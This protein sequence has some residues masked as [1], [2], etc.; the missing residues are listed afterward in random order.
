MA[1]TT[2]YLK[3]PYTGYVED[4]RRWNYVDDAA[5]GG[6]LDPDKI[7][8]YLRR[9]RTGGETAKDYQE[10]IDGAEADLLYPKTLG[11]PGGMMAAIEA[12]A[13][14][15]W[16]R[17]N[18]TLGLGQPDEPDLVAGGQ[19]SIA[20]RLTR[21]YDGENTPLRLFWR[22]VPSRMLRREQQFFVVEGQSITRT[23]DEEGN[24][25]NE[26]LT[27]SSCVKAVK[28][29]RV[30]GRRYEGGRLVEAIITGKRE[31][32]AMLEDE[33]QT[34]TTYTHYTL[35]GWTRNILVKGEGSGGE[36]ARVIDS[37][38]Y[39]YYESAEDKRN[40]VRDQPH[41][42]RLPIV[43]TNLSLDG[44]LGYLLAVNAIGIWNM[45]SRRDG[46]INKGN[47]ATR[48]DE[49]PDDEA[50]GPRPSNTS[51]DAH[52]EAAREGY[53]TMQAQPG[54]KVYD[55]APPMAPAQEARATIAEKRAQFKEDA[56]QGFVDA[57]SQ[58][59]ATKIR[60]DARMGIEVLASSLS[61]TVDGAENECMLLIEQ[62]EFPDSPDQWHQFNVERSEAFAPAEPMAVFQEEKE[63]I[64]GSQ[65]TVP[66]TPLQ[67]A[68]W[69][70]DAARM[71]GLPEDESGVKA[72][73][74]QRRLVAGL[75]DDDLGGDGSAGDDVGEI[76]E[77]LKS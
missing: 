73:I 76:L 38:T 20:Y 70:N 10:R 11:T 74:A 47:Y 7:R 6:Y 77:G 30:T 55:I 61:A 50:M 9:N 46:Y 2:H 16:M 37:G 58:V 57:G 40:A 24:V 27:A 75:F 65:E 39:D 45:T 48:I 56:Y 54:A 18:A 41:R 49:A 69:T 17:E 29:Q 43:E 31:E 14:R 25:T 68:N 22:A 42:R 33:A 28:P 62:A 3:R 44:H 36:T 21:N 71:L 63:A 59:T 23:T 32:Q 8:Q 52:E 26:Q 34:Q 64:F 5:T 19:A 51:Y 13:T 4:A 53:D 60:Q 15:R 67:K 1:D 35:D 66:F 12:D 72:E